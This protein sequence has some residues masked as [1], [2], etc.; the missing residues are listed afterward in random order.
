[1]AIDS[2][3]SN[4]ERTGAG[5][6]DK[7]AAS[8]LKLVAEHGL[9]TA[10]A[11]ASGRSSAASGAGVGAQA[12]EPDGLLEK[13]GRTVPLWVFVAALALFLLVYGLQ[14]HHASRLEVEVT[15][16]EESLASAEARLESHRSHLNEI[17]SGI[18]DLTTRLDGLRALIDEDPTTRA[19]RES[20]LLGESPVE[21]PADTP[22]ATPEPAD[23]ASTTP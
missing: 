9:P 2:N 6:A 22:R 23:A 14:T 5:H 4:D 17:R 20:V 11:S 15:R 1:M 13:P 12:S 3:S 16:L 8:G 7:L 10:A 21:K 18:A 19:A